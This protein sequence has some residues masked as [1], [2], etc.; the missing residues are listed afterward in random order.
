MAIGM[1]MFQ[2]PFQKVLD[3]YIEGIIDEREFLSL[4]EYFKRWRFNYNLYKPIL[5]FAR[6]NSIPVVALNMDREIIDKV[7]K[8]GIDS[9]TESERKRIPADMDFSDSEYMERI[10]EV[11]KY[12]KDWKEKNF[13]FFF[14]SQILWDETMSL[15]IV[16]FLKSNPDRQMVVIAGQGHLQ[17]GSGIPKRTFRR[18]GENY[19]I[20]LIDASLIDGIADHVVFPKPVE[21]ITSPKLMVFLNIKEENLNISGFPD[22]SVSEK[23]GLQAGDIIISMDG[24]AVSSIEDVKIHL[25]YKKSGD[26]V[27]VKVLRSENNRQEEIEY[28]VRL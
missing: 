15:S 22:K 10:S 13:D 7:S 5:R 20:I 6:S 4:S 19:S 23:A 3:D 8:N 21:G 28:K 2:R 24:N 27:R 12:H 11:F 16:D 9:L 25:F 26:V 18:N 17:F 1:E 14:Q